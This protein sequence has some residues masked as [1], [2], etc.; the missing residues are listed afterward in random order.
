MAPVSR[1]RLQ[2]QQV[3][4]FL[5]EVIR[6]YVRTKGL[7]MVLHDPFQVRLPR[8]DRAR[9]VLF[10]SNE[11]L[12]RPTEHYL[13]GAADLVVEVISPKAVC[14]IAMRSFLSVRVGGGQEYWL[15]DSQRHQVEFYQLVEH[16]VY[17]S[18]LPDTERVYQSRF[19]EGFYLLV[20]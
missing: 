5:L 16:R 18:V 6:L 9:D 7:G 3:A 11:N 15:V 17:C 2:H 8:S 20:E 10:V 4:G 13:E 14:A 1:V 19:I 12:S